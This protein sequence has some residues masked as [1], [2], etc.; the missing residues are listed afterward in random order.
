MGIKSTGRGSSDERRPT[1]AMEDYLKTIF[2]LIET[3]RAARVKDIARRLDVRMSSVTSMLKSLDEKGLVQYRKYE[4][5]VLTAS[6]TRIAREIYRRNRI[7]LRF[8]K[9]ILTTE[10]KTAAREACKMEHQLSPATLD[11]LVA[12]MNMVESCPQ[13]AEEWPTRFQ[14]FRR[15]RVSGNPFRATPNNANLGGKTRHQFA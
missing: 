11:S 15:L 14:A 13:A 10:E 8:L 2:M 1:P 9:D 3:G 5:L 7:L 12:V 4:D 6:G